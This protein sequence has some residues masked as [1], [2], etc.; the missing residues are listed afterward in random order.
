MYD[1]RKHLNDLGVARYIEGLLLTERFDSI[2][3]EIKQH[4]MNCTEC[5]ERVF[6][7]YD[8][9]RQDQKYIDELSKA[10]RFTHPVQGSE[11]QF[12][13]TRPI[14]KLVPK[15]LLYAASFLILVT[16]AIFLLN[17]KETSHQD[18]FSEYFMAYP[19]ILTQKS[20]HIEQ[21]MLH[22]ALY[23]Y[24]SEEYNA[25]VLAFQEY[26]TQNPNDSTASFYLAISYLAE[27]QDNQAKMVLQSLSGKLRESSLKT[28]VDWYLALT[29]LKSGNVEQ[30]REIF[31]ELAAGSTTYAKKASE[32]LSEL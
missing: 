9:D 24:N 21:E 8:I 29:F 13:T 32:L 14:I 5:R 27:N 28:T 25:A 23:Y 2:P 20:G 15:V 18:I 16:G 1:N 6:V 31:E 11:S 3:E 7:Q 12:T 26:L 22:T 10:D 4:V 30:S 17:V 19:D